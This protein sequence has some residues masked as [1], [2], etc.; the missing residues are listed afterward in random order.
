[1]YIFLM[2]SILSDSND[3]FTGVSPF[4][5]LH[6]FSFFLLDLQILGKNNKLS[7]N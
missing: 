7:L 1:M 2:Y 4:S 3:N 5:Y 6:F